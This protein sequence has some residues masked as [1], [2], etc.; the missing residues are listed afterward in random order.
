MK[1]KHGVYNEFVS[2]FDIDGK[3]NT[4]EVIKPT[5]EDDTVL[6]RLMEIAEKNSEGE[7]CEDKFDESTKMNGIDRKKES[8]MAK[9]MFC[10]N[11][12]VEFYTT[13]ELVNFFSGEKEKYHFE[14]LDAARVYSY[15]VKTTI[16][17]MI[18]GYDIYK[19][20]CSP[21]RERDLT[22]IDYLLS[23]ESI[24]EF[25]Q[26]D[27]VHLTWHCPGTNETCTSEEVKEALEWDRRQ[28][29]HLYD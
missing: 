20:E 17:D 12:I 7:I 3:G 2:M 24:R 21:A 28:G 16:G 27:N 26:R 8:G 10:R 19:I 9:N 25:A 6:K 4:K 15:I 1:K 5:A 29:W 23:N 14:I 11:Y 22:L 13:D 18:L